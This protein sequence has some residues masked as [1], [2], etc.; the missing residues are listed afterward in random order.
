MYQ[1]SYAENFK[2]SANDCRHRER[3]ALERSIK[4]LERG[5]KEGSRSPD[6]IEGLTY[7]IDLWNILISD[8]I[9]P[10]NDLPD[11]LRA[12]LISVGFWI[13]KEADLIRQNKSDNIKDL[14]DICTSVSNG[15]R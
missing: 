9:S 12:D 11:V 8:L 5:A 2:E 13:I 10:E 3:M 14:I 1:N 15:L 4:L 7:L 6:C